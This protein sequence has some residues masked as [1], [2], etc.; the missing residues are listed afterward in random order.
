MVERNESSC[1]RVD[2]INDS[3]EGGDGYPDL[4][5]DM[6]QHRDAMSIGMKNVQLRRKSLTNRF[7]HRNVLVR[8]WSYRGRV[9]AG[10]TH[11]CIERHAISRQ[12][13]VSV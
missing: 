1:S 2:A 7:D 3:S 4:V 11:S 12:S 8:E 5:C 10:C 9:R 13:H 6:C